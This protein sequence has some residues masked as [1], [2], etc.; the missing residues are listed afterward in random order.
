MLTP[1]PQFLPLI[2]PFL[3]FSSLEVLA[4][5]SDKKPVL[6]LT[7]FSLTYNRVSVDIIIIIT[8]INIHVYVHSYLDQVSTWYFAFPIFPK[9]LKAVVFLVVNIYS[10]NSS[11]KVA[12]GADFCYFTLQY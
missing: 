4:A 1:P 3:N 7:V 2:T 11:W 12:M 9:D 5:C 8:L 10:T 6:H